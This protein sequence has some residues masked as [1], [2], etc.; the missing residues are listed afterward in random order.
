M[1]VVANGEFAQSYMHH[2]VMTRRL[3]SV[4]KLR[5]GSGKSTPEF[6]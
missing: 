5:L 2:A 1:T 4:E 6:R 3:I